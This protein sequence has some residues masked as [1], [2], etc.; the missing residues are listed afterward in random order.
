MLGHLFFDCFLLSELF[1]FFDFA[2]FEILL[3]GLH[4]LVKKLHGFACASCGLLLFGVEGKFVVLHSTNNYY[5]PTIVLEMPKQINSSLMCFLLF[6][7]TLLFRL[8]FLSAFGLRQFL[9][10]CIAIFLRFWLAS[11]LTLNSPNLL[12]I[13]L[14]PSS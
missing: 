14:Y 11:R 7:L 1:L 13:G 8:F 4:L 12:V 10:D 6:H 9:D 2:G 5:K 3:L